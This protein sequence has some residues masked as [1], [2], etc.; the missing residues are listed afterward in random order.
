MASVLRAE[1][2]QIHQP[3]VAF[4][5]ACRRRVAPV[6]EEAARWVGPEAAAALARLV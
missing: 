1:G 3:D 2:V 5:A 6:L 4:L